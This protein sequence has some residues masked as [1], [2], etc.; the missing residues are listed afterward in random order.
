MG[1]PNLGF[2]FHKNRVFQANTTECPR[3]AIYVTPDLQAMLLHQFS[4][5]DMV[6]VKLSRTM[7]QGGDLLIASC[8]MPDTA[9]EPFTDLLIEAINFFKEKKLPLL[10]GCDANAHH[11]VWGSTNVNP[12]GTALLQFIAMNGLNILNK[13]NTPDFVTK[14]QNGSAKYNTD[15]RRTGGSD[16]FVE[17]LPNAKLFRSSVYPIQSERCC[18]EGRFRNPRKTN[19]EQY[20]GFLTQH[21]EVKLATTLLNSPSEPR[22]SPYS[23]TV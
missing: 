5:R 19:W 16:Q 12:R 1:H 2:G 15:L 23:F 3:G 18:A 22:I 6:V 10:L 17:S 4:D 7:A 8:Y 20:R 21:V 9:V 11:V 14:K 13:G